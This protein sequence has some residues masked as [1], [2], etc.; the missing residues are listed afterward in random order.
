MATVCVG[1]RRSPRRPALRRHRRAGAVRGNEAT[2]L[3]GIDESDA[4]PSRRVTVAA[5]LPRTRSD[6]R[7]VAPTA[8]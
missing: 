4:K 6:L 7:A 5:A 2:S 8:S 1:G 3:F